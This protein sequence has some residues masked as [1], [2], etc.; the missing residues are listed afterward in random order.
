MC[1]RLYNTGIEPATPGTQTLY[2]RYLFQVQ[3]WKDHGEWI[4]EGYQVDHINDNPLDDRIENFQLL[5]PQQNI[6]KRD[7]ANYRK[8][9]VLPEMI[10]HIRVLLQDGWPYATVIE[11]LGLSY[12]HLRH[13]VRTRFP[14]FVADRIVELNGAS[15]KEM[16]AKGFSQLMI[17]NQFDVSQ[18]TI[19]RFI[20]DNLPEC[21]KD[22]IMI[23][24]LAVVE[25]GLVKG[26]SNV[27]IAERLGMSDASICLYIKRFFPDHVEAR[28]MV[29]ERDRTDNL[30]KIKWLLDAKHTQGE[31]AQ[32]LELSPWT[33]SNL[34]TNY[35]PDYMH[36]K[37]YDIRVK[38]VGELLKNGAQRKEIAEKLGIRPKVVSSII[39]RF[40]PEYGVETTRT[41]IFDKFKAIVLSGLPYNHQ[42][43][44]DKLGVSRKTIS[45]YLN[46][47][48]PEQTKIGRT[49]KLRGQIQ[50][51]LA[52]TDEKLTRRQI[53]ERLGAEYSCVR[54]IFRNGL[55]I[56]G[57]KE[58]APEMHAEIKVLLDAGATFADISERFGIGDRRLARLI[59]RH[60][61]EVYGN[62][63]KVAEY[64]AAGMAQSPGV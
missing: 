35:L 64:R 32:L 51:L 36:Q 11:K 37:A 57:T 5:T 45:D 28:L 13:L 24:R 17:A 23:R 40:Y 22:A 7:E 6:Q 10:D 31:I 15:I 19:S 14:E 34:V 50:L 48:F 2:S 56:T 41:E 47:Y 39:V 33:V 27:Q 12:G 25:D 59:H 18:I 63:S 49:N 60:F 46:T 55:D 38:R 61:P 43:V 54:D 62:R 58:V 1:V 53:A 30:R 29:D 4:P 3:Y 26:E 52:A 21:K 8:N 16:V 44:A 9:P 42:A 20:R